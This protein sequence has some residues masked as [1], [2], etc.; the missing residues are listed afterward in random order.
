M[1]FPLVFSPAILET[2]GIPEYDRIAMLC[3]F[4][5]LAAAFPCQSIPL[6]RNI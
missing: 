6:Q 2:S 4:Q 5:F 3:P 1:A